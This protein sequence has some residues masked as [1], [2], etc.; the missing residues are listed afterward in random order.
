M[1]KETIR[2]IKAICIA[3]EEEKVKIIK[4]KESIRELIWTVEAIVESADRGVEQLESGVREL[5]DG[6]DALSEYM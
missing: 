3:I 4:A 6:I 1:D 5:N 2:Q